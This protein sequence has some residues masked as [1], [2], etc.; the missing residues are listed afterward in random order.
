MKKLSCLLVFYF[1]LMNCFAADE[2]EESPS[3]QEEQEGS[4]VEV[5]PGPHP[6]GGGRHPGLGKLCKF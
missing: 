2:T 4:F 5:H 3:W 1:I 6:S